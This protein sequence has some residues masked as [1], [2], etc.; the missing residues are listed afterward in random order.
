[1]DD[2]LLVKRIKV[3]SRNLISSIAFLVLAAIGDLNAQSINYSNTVN[4]TILFPGNTTFSFSPGVDNFSITSGSASGLLG[5]ISGI[6]T[7]GTITTIDGVSSA[8]VTGIGGFVIHDGSFN[9]TA[10]L[11]WVNI[12]QFGTGGSLN[13]AGSVNLT[14]ITY[15]GSNPDLVTLAAAGSSSDVLTFQFVPQVSLAALRD[16][17]GP[18]STSFSGSIANPEPGTT[19]LV[20][21]GLGLTSAIGWRRKKNA[22]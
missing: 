22:A 5:E 15:G 11:N 4:S 13:L 16:G 8:P 2:P 9:L 7:I 3:N 10:N 19:G 14:G 6:F 18:H 12:A 20:I 1:V 21:L 17:P